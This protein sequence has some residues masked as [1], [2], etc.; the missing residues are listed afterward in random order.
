MERRSVGL[1][2]V[3]SLVTCGLYT[4]YWLYSLAEDMD[5]LDAVPKEKA[6]SEFDEKKQAAI[7]LAEE[8]G[9]EFVAEWKEF[10][11]YRCGDALDQLRY[12]QGERAGYLGIL[13]LLLGVFSLGIISYALMQAELNSYADY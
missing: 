1:C 8:M 3:L 4:L 12:S 10:L 6:F 13:Y 2:I 11:I 5:R 9:W 7:A